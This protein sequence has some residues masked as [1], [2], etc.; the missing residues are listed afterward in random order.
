MSESASARIWYQSFVDPAEQRPYMDRLQQ[1]LA[2]IA[3]PGFT[4]EVHGMSPPDRYLHPLTEFRCAGQTIRNALEAERQGYD[5]FLIGHFQEPGLH[6]C[7]ASLEIPV[8]GLGEASMLYACTLGRKVGLITIAPVFIPWH[9]D[10]IARYGLKERVVGVRAVQTSVADYMRSLE[11]PEFYAQIREQFRH[12]AQPLVELG[13][14]VLI[15]AGGLP[16]LL[17]A[18]ERNFAIGGAVIL[19]GI[20]VAAKFVEVALKLRRIN[21]TGVSRASW[22]AKAPAEAVQEFLATAT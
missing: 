8:V 15:P 18:N 9:E 13:V 3:D 21:G 10:Q 22:Y 20:A 16:M 19:N 11:D 4:Y 12:Q 5:A 14:E 17:F 6:E 7:K 1:Y 2:S